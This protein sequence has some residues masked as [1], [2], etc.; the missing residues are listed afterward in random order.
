MSISDA[1]LLLVYFTGVIGFF[2]IALL[3]ILR[4]RTPV[5]V[6][7]AL[8]AAQVG[9]W[10]LLQLMAQIV[11]SN[12][13]LATA[14]LHASVASAGPMV[15]TFL[16]FAYIYANRKPPYILLYVLGGIAGLL[17]LFSENIR[18]VTITYAGIGVPELDIWYAGLLLF[19][20]F[21]IIAAAAII[22][23]HLRTSN[24]SK[25]GRRQGQ[26]LLLTM[27][28]AGMSVIA[29]SFNTSE[30]SQTVI[31][32]HIVPTVCLFGMLSYLYVIYRGLFDIHFFVIRSLTYVT[33]LF[34]L[35]IFCVVPVVYSIAYYAGYSG[36]ALSLAGI[37]AIIVAAIYVSHYLRNLFDRLTTRLFYRQYYNPQDVIDSIN[38][39]LVRTIDIDELA[40]GATDV[41][42][43]ALKPNFLVITVGPTEDKNIQALRQEVKGLAF[44]DSNIVVLDDLDHKNNANLR[45]LVKR[46]VAVVVRL[47]VAQD[48]IGYMFVGYRQSGEIY[49]SRDRRLLNTVADELALGFQNAL[50]FE[51]IRS[52]N[53]TL[54]QK[55]DEATARLRRTNAK[56]RQLDE[57]K[58]E[59]V[60]MASHQLRT[61]LTSV[62]GYLSMVLDGDAGKVTPSQEK[63]LKEAYGSSQRMVYLIADFLNVS[64]LKTGKFMLEYSPVDM[65]AVV[66]D[67]VGQLRSVAEARGLTL[68]Y[69]EPAHVPLLRLDETKMRQVVMNLIDNAIYYS[70]P[71]TTVTIELFVRGGQLVFRVRDKGIGVP[72]A[73]QHGLFEKF[74]RATNARKS[75]P[76]GTGIGLYMIKKVVD[77]HGGSIIFASTEGRGS[78]FGFSLALADKRP[79]ADKL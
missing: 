57:A 6:G 64:R 38:N 42:S 43:S 62:K 77:A 58:D 56:L 79:G 9:L 35:A 45:K 51:E 40:R 59:F 47:A 26:V 65:A 24:I 8:F 41:L 50:R 74:F 70:R 5:N 3:V 29:S 76:D 39:V 78:T 69:D 14:F 75:R 16:I 63:L 20:A 12:H 23:V 11:S 54:Q 30:F 32:Q 46:R 13:V 71:Q 27:L 44:H 37:S 7:F 2:A 19:S 72:T 36:S 31:G 21:C 49:A 55:V 33:A 15:A 48:D 17:T 53:L 73:E 61:P 1:L 10:Q 67:E 66:R 52:F 25:E 34:I 28:V 68:H 22:A 18:T 60:S 4:K